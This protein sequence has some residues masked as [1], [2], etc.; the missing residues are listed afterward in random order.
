MHLSRPLHRVQIVITRKLFIPS[1]KYNLFR[2]KLNFRRLIAVAKCIYLCKVFDLGP[3]RARS[4]SV[5][6][7]VI[8]DYGRE[9]F[10]NKRLNLQLAAVRRRARGTVQDLELGLWVGLFSIYT[11]VCADT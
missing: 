5:S 4:K 11:R 3:R 1:S 10:Q 6:K 2:A 7:F 8:I 9:R